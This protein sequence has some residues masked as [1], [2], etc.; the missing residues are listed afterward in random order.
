MANQRFVARALFFLLGLVASCS[1]PQ[2]GATRVIA[3]EVEKRVA[4]GDGVSF[5]DAGPYETLVGK[6]TYTLDPT[7]SHNAGIVDAQ[8]AA[9]SDGLVRYS[10]DVVVVKPVDM[11][12][13]NGV[14]LYHVVNRGNFDR[15]ILSS[16]GWKE[17]ASA[18]C[19]S[20]ERIG[21][22][23][24]QGF[25]IAF[26]GWQ[27][28][29]T[30]EEN[31]LQLFVPQTRKEG[32]A[33]GGEVLAEIQGKASQKVASLGA[34]GHKAYLVD[35]EQKAAAEMRQHGSYA[36]P[37]TLIDSQRW[38]FAKL[39]DAG[40]PEPD[41][42]HVYFPEGFDPDKTYTVRYVTNESPAM[43]LCFSAV[44]DLISFLCGTDGSNPLLDTSGN[45]RIR[46]RLAYGSSQSGRFL[47]NFLYQG[48]NRSLEGTRVFD[49]IY[50]N[51]PGCRMGFFN[52]RHAQ[53]SRAW[54]FYPN[55]DFP[56]TD[57][58]TT[59]PETGQTGGILERVTPPFLPKLFYIHHS[60]EYW[61]S[62]AA[63]THVSLDG[64]NDADLP[65]NV[66]IYSFAG[67][68]HGFAELEEG[69]PNP[70]PDYLLPFNPNPT[71][72]LEDPLLE[73]LTDWVV[74]DRE[75]PP[76]SYPRLERAEL[77][78]VDQFLFPDTPDTGAPR[79]V[80][81]H[82]RFNWGP[83]FRDGILTNPLPG[84]GQPF[85]TLV[86][87]VGPDGNELSGI[88]TP[89][90]AV[91][92]ASYTGWNFPAD[93]YRSPELTR[94]ARLSGAW[95][96]FCS[97]VKEKKR[98]QDSRPSL[99]ERYQDLESYLTKLREATE[100]LISRRLMFE[101]DI[102]LVLEQGAAMYNYVAEHGSWARDQK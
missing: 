41:R 81:V 66:R 72:L 21:R 85:P 64:L 84:I 102:D 97:D 69:R 27:A 92:V 99:Q 80:E 89:H 33:I 70:M 54:G 26:S 7:D 56:F 71:Y 79:I 14:L 65:D 32:G 18:P 98:R 100:A 40:E 4:L 95:L 86:P 57:L 45:S 31:R 24:Q 53:P 59:D 52:Y 37:G 93:M 12:R 101:E 44:R 50:A 5:R 67:T 75:P 36:D 68:A 60:G 39:N 1:V 46:H 77:V 19:G 55:F 49:G 76:N 34:S 48:F 11:A 63:L 22:L 23:M 16:E 38:S 3:F 25:T 28:D 88:K 51:V 94:A 8:S 91:P 82:P 78:P 20:R 35:P 90:V 58:A 42:E 43:G 13:G 17:I 83:D 10:A 30:G 15:R 2:Q 9:A 74:L 6:A 47:R 73:A 62:G 96:P 29:V 61:S 87:V